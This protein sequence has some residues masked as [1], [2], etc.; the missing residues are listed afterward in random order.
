MEDSSKN[1]D[2][3]TTTNTT[4]EKQNKRELERWE[5]KLIIESA[6]VKLGGIFSWDSTFL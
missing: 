3:D 1:N 2:T 5:R 6:K 4:K